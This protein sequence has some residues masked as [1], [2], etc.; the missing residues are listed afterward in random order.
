MDKK[1]EPPLP[2][3]WAHLRFAVIGP[4]LAAPPRRS[5]LRRAL[6]ELVKQEWL[7]PTTGQPT[8]FAFSTLERWYYTARRQRQDPV[9]ALRKKDRRDR[10]KHRSLS[11]RLVELLRAQYRE[12]PS[13]SF[14]LHHDN[15]AVLAAADATVG[16]M[17]SYASLRRFMHAHALLRRRRITSRLSSGQQQAAARLEEREVRSFECDHVN[18]LWHA[19]FHHGSLPVVTPQGEWVRPVVLGVLDDRSRLACHVQWYLE[20]TAQT[21]VHGLCQAFQKRALP[22]KFLTDNGSPM[23]AAETQQGLR[24]LSVI[25]DTTLPYSP[26]QN[27]KQESFWGPLEGRL[28][29]MLEGCRELTLEILNRA[30]QAWCELEY[31]RS[32][33]SEIGTTP[34]KRY[35]EGPDVGRDSPPSD[36]LRLAFGAEEIRTQ[37]RSDGTVSIEGRRFEVPARFRHLKRLTVR[38]ARWDLSRIS[39]I[40]PRNDVVLDRLY[41]LDK[42]KNADGQRRRLPEP[43]V[44]LES[45]APETR[46]GEI[47]PLLKKLLAEYAAT[48]LPPGYLPLEPTT[49]KK[50]E[51]K[52]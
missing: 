9:A 51:E 14:Q 5:E 38:F 3:R 45:S 1:D 46:S 8:R 6:R 39:L 23:L 12:H 36:A 4:L 17:P 2:R 34:L 11:S 41:P 27:G 26:Y 30:T 47:A 19:D 42:S 35:L 52:S 32:V 7:H 31:N 16:T 10:G 28:M 48:G 33:H 40:D 24:R 25:H 37:R 43:A 21:F 49:D 15:L 29:A 50:K 18:G 13:W 20:E 44:S 22:G